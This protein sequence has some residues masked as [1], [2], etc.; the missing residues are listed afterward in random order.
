[1]LLRRRGGSGDVVRG[2]LASILVAMAATAACSRYPIV[3]VAE[4]ERAKQRALEAEAPLYAPS[5]YRR[6]QA[7][8]KSAQLLLAEQERRWLLRD[9]DA[10]ADLLQQ[11][12]ALAESAAANATEERARRRLEVESELLQFEDA[13]VMIREGELALMRQSLSKAE[14]SLA[15]AKAQWENGDYEAARRTLTGEAEAI[16]FLNDLGEAYVQ[17]NTDPELI[18]QWNRA[19]RSTIEHSAR[20]GEHVIIVNKYRKMLSLYRNGRRVND[21]PA[22]LGAN[23]FSEKRYRGDRATPEGRY[24]IVKKLGVGQSAYYKA[25][26]INYPNAQ[27]QERYRRLR[28]EMSSAPGV[29]GSIE[30]HG[31]GG[32]NQNWTAG[33]VAVDDR[34]MDRL[35]EVASVGTLV[36]IVANETVQGLGNALNAN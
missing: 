10:A 35:F 30:I 9:Y 33:C 28:R 4:A 21:H 27:D 36:T 7:A 8:F 29:G 15:A 18:A 2:Y 26:V 24:R 32:R 13:L 16:R 17:R 25:L 19:V 12:R 6:S 1:M 3:S 34:V 20:T 22:D 5:E 14:I 31:R 23:P 11:A